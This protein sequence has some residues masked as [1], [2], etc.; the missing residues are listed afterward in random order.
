MNDD[1]LTSYSAR[2]TKTR[3][4][5]LQSI[6]DEYNEQREPN[7]PKKTLKYVHE[8]FIRSHENEPHFNLKIR[9]LDLQSEIKE[10]QED[11]EIQ[12]IR[13]N[14]KETELKEIQSQLNNK[15]LDSY[16]PEP[17][18]IKLTPRL[19]NA[20]HNLIGTCQQRSFNNFEEIPNE[21]FT[22]VSGSFEVKRT[23]L[24]RYVKNNF[25]SLINEDL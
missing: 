25:D 3:K 24:I 6:I 14:R 10:I 4:H 23:D 7:E 13:L 8:F 9:M 18:Q 21:L 15:S 20:V 16:K 2:L 11:I 17:K 1:N 22:A 12:Q 5:Q 19:E